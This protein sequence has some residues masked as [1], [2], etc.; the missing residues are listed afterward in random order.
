[1]QPAKKKLQIRKECRFEQLSLSRRPKMQ[2]RAFLMRA[3][4]GVA[5]TAIARPASAQTGA[6]V[7]WRLA[8]SWPKSLDTLYGGV[9]AM[10]QRVGQMTDRKFQIQCFAG[11]EI[12]PPLQVWDATQNGTVECGHTLTSFNIGKNPAVAFDSGLAFGL[13]TRQQQAWMNYGGGLELIRA[14]F[15]KDGILPIPCGNVG[16]QMGGFYRKEINSVDDLK[17]LKFRIGGLGGVILAKL[18][19]VPLQIPT[20]DIYPSLE[21]G[22]IDAAEWIGPYDDE[23][24]GLH[25]VARYYYYPGWWEG[26]AQVTLLVNLQHWE[27]LPESYRAALEAACAEATVL[28]MAK[29]DTRNPEALR[30]LV[31]SGVQ[32]RQ[33][34]RPVLDACY[35][36]AFETYD[37][38]A[39]R[40]PDF[41]LIYESWQKFLADSNLWFRI[42]ENTLDN[43][44]FAMS[45]Q[46][47]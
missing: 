18:G 43:Y 11:G 1:M 45:A 25:K 36:A 9:E 30:R 41:K 42:A 3:R 13:N 19:V 23:K 47:R 39:G 29:Y 26:S 44:R 24:L 21:R 15:K 35:K 5:A 7:R 20:A 31:A 14:L 28:M 22:A 17:G 38:L 10:C 27:A 4:A 34:P 33:F 40:S 12:V 32:L 46:P 8:T 2:R 6:P 16:V 37:E